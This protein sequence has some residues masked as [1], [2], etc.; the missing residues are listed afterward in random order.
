VLAVSFAACGR[1][2]LGPPTRGINGRNLAFI[3]SVYEERYTTLSE[4][5]ECLGPGKPVADPT[6]LKISPTRPLS[7]QAG[8]AYVFWGSESG[9]HILVGHDELNQVHY[10]SG[11][12][13]L[14][15]GF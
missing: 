6:Q 7:P 15:D 14:S 8:L 4:V 10:V 9:D 5:E 1:D 2:S 12:A 3:E 13:S 11:K